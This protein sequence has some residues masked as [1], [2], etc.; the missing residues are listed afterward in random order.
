[1]VTRGLIICTIFAVAPSIDAGQAAVHVDPP[2]LQGPRVLE[3]HTQDTAVRNYLDAWQTIKVAFESNSVTLLDRDFVG[4]ARD[5][6]AG[7]IQQQAAAGIQT[8]YV[9]KSHDIQ[10]A[11]YSPEGLSLQLIDNVEYE[12]QILN[13]D[14]VQATQAVHARYI[15]VLTPA[16]V[17]WR[18]RVLQADFEP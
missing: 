8:R 16:E 1:M 11:F 7:A 14:R 17:R 6:L 3:E 2:H 12:V 18:V 4:T 9:D 15:V 10:F 5:K 13:H